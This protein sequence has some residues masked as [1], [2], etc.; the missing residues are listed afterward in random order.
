MAGPDQ[1]PKKRLSPWPIAIGVG[2]SVVIVVNVV[3]LVVAS[4]NPPVIETSEYYDKALHHQTTIEER[5]ASAALGWSA[6]VTLAGGKLRYALKGADGQPVAGLKGKVGL[7]RNETTA[8][9]GV[10]ALTEAGPGIYE[11]QPPNAKA[12][13]WRLE[14]RFEGGPAPWLDARTVRV[15]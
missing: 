8:L 1:P 4:R 5:K 9:D 14:A 11:A 6:E 15:E 12:G 10:V 2:L 7:K 13:L 3:F